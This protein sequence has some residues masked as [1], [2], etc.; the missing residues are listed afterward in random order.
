MINDK[1]ED[2]GPDEGVA[3]AGAYRAVMREREEQTEEELEKYLQE[4]YR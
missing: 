3:A 4:R 1:D 2:L